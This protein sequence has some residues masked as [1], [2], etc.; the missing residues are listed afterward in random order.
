MAASVRTA[1]ASF[2][3]GFSSFGVLWSA[4]FPSLVWCAMRGGPIDYYQVLYGAGS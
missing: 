1:T 4:T 2:P 3:V